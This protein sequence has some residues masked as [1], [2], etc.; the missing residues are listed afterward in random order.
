MRSIVMSS[1]SEKIFFHAGAATQGYLGDHA[2]E[3]LEA[4]SREAQN[5]G[6][7]PIETAEV[8]REFAFRKI[9]LDRMV[10]ALEM[11]GQLSSLWEIDHRTM[12]VFVADLYRMFPSTG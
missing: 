5:V 2:S 11:C 6:L 1:K 10:G 8:L 9:P 7:G 4:V 3:A 12:A